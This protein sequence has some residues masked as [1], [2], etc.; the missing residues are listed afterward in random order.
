MS[1]HNLQQFDEALLDEIG[2]SSGMSE[3]AEI[4]EAL[5]CRK[6]VRAARS[7]SVRISRREQ[8]VA[9][10]AAVVCLVSLV[11]A[12]RAQHRA[13]A[14]QERLDAVEGRI[15]GER[16]AVYSAERFLGART[17]RGPQQ[18]SSAGV[19]CCPQ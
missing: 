12:F 6:R 2:A 7:A 1:T 8:V 15:R 4:R 18:S 9:V 13:E 5:N 3:S 14:L 11:Y 17:S 10:I 19:P 16:V